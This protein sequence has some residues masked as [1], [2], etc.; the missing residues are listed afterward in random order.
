MERLQRTP[1]EYARDYNV[2]GMVAMI[3]VLCYHRKSSNPT[4]VD[5]IMIMQGK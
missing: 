1:L 5:D 3:A 4:E 2:G